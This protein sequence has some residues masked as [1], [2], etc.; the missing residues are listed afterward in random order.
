MLDL[1]LLQ[2]DAEL[3]CELN[4][5]SLRIRSDGDRKLVFELTNV[6]SLFALRKIAGEVTSLRKI[7]CR[8]NRIEQTVEVLAAGQLIARFG[9]KANSRLLNLIRVRSTELRLWRLLTLVMKG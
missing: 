9:R 7:G 8:L 1:R 4:G 5:N 3:A 6:K 2:I